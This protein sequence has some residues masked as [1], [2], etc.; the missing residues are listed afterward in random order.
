MQEALQKLYRSTYRLERFFKINAPEIFIEKEKEL[1]N[2]YL[3]QLQEQF[4]IDGEQFLQ[5]DNGKIEYLCFCATEDHDT[6]LF[7]RCHRCGHY[8][9]N[10]N[11]TQPQHSFGCLIFQNDEPMNCEHFYDTNMELPER[12][13]ASIEHCTKCDHYKIIAPDPIETCELNHNQFNLT[14][15]F[16]KEKK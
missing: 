14:C 9:F 13:L 3:K 12:I 15:P 7:D 2:N 16:L 5:S 6:K 11:K 1:R 8:Y 4:N 10:N